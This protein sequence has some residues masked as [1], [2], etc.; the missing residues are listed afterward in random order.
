MP[1]P[2]QPPIPAPDS[3]SGAP[4]REL[5]IVLPTAAA[6][7]R[8]V[9]PPSPAE[10]GGQLRRLERKRRGPGTAT[11]RPLADDFY[12][13]FTCASFRLEQIEIDEPAAAAALRAS[14]R[15][16]QLRPRSQ[17][18]IRNHVAILR[19]IE[20]AVRRGDVLKADAVVRWYTS[21]GCGLSIT[22]IEPAAHDRL[23]RCLDRIHSPQLRLRQALADAAALH[24]QLVNDPLFPSFNGLIARLL[25][26]LHLRRCGLPGVTLDRPTDA[27]ALQVASALEARLAELVSRAYD[28]PL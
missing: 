14:P 13:A 5:R 9:S 7:A 4:P 6:P 1:L 21:I 17:R 2:Q 8:P 23:T 24:V 10:L 3:P 28:P 19:T 11:T 12:L 27:T 25:L 16:G 15:V 18:R 20:H 26:H 22:G